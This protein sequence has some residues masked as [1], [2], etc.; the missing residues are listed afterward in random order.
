MGCKIVRTENSLKFTQ[1]VQMQCYSDKFELP[2]RSYKTS[3]QVVSVL[4]AG[5]KDEAQS[6]VLQKKYCSGT[7]KAMHALHYS[8]PETYIAVQDLYVCVSWFLTKG[9]NF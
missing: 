3:V 9:F 5:K 1:S 8:K 6:S 2:T 7:G 4:V